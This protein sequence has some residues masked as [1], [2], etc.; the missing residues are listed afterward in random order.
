MTTN[1]KSTNIGY[2]SYSI[3]NMIVKFFD[4]SCLSKYAAVT[5]VLGASY[6]AGSKAYADKFVNNTMDYTTINATIASA[7]S[8]EDVHFAAGTY[9]LPQVQ[10]AKFYLNNQ[11]VDLVADGSVILRGATIT[12]GAVVGIGSIDSRLYQ[13]TIE[14]AAKGVILHANFDPSFPIII[15]GNTIQNVDTGISWDN[16]DVGVGIDNSFPSVIVDGNYI[17]A[18]FAGSI[19]DNQS[20]P[21]SETTAWAQVSNNT[22]EQVSAVVYAPPSYGLVT[23]AGSTVIVPGLGYFSGNLNI[24]NNAVTVP[25]SVINGT[26]G[27]ISNTASPGFPDA[28]G[29]M[30]IANCRDTNSCTNGGFVE[31]FSERWGGNNV[32][33]EDSNDA[34]VSWSRRPIFR[35]PGNGPS[36]PFI[37]VGKC[38]KIDGS[39]RGYCGAFLP[40]GDVNG[41]VILNDIDQSAL[42]AVMTENGVP[43]TLENRAVFDFDG[44]GDIDSHDLGEFTRGYVGQNPAI[45]TAS[46]WGLAN[47][48]L[49]TLIGGTLALRRPP[50]AG[51]RGSERVIACRLRS[52]FGIEY[53]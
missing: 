30:N 26:P 23:A 39:D 32:S 24:D 6:F 33:S 18:V 52:G 16:V 38:K 41:D 5:A 19:F 50:V 43:A 13:F 20:N 40:M 47:L 11:G 53:H 17:K 44:D 29:E 25:G 2:I 37:G 22:F 9:Q 36:S 3:V 1:N 27:P 12:S 10:G 8:G 21:Q 48:G 51:A 35:K 34:V 15:Q 14:N 28:N 45:P 7:V 46:S 4:I 42:L 49:L 31:Y